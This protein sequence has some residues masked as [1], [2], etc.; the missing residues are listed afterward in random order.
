MD[1]KD[2]YEHLANIYLDASKKRKIKT[3]EPRRFR[4]LFLV[5]IFIIAVLTF[6]IIANSLNKKSLNNEVALII[7]PDAVRIN[8]NFNSMKKE[9]YTVDLNNLNLARFK[10]IGFSL[11]KTDPNDVVYLRVELVSAFNE[12][13]EVYLKDI[14]YHWKKFRISLSDF[15]RLSEW[16][17]MKKLSFIVE[18][19]NTKNKH[20]VVYIDD[21]KFI[22]N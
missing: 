3:K 21:V 1:K 13:S 15:K 8:Y 17:A 19:W 18:E 14:R 12:I 22:K 2:I 7:Q 10:E 20:G 11:R 9:A 16:S 6:F 5:S 4:N